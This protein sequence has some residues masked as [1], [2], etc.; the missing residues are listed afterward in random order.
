MQSLMAEI[1]FFYVFFHPIGIIIS[2][3]IDD[4][5]TVFMLTLK[6]KPFSVCFWG[7]V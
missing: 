1:M 6:P 4:N 2:K 7:D 3:V 5:T